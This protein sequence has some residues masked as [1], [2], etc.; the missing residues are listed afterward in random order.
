MR[1]STLEDWEWLDDEHSK[2]MLQQLIDEEEDLR[3]N[4]EMAR[5]YYALFEKQI[6][7][8]ANDAREHLGLDSLE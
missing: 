5:Q 7:V 3:V 2:K 4:E 1:G 6:M 8:V